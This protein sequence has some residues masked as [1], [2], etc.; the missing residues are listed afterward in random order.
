VWCVRR[1]TTVYACLFP[2]LSIYMGICKW[3]VSID[4]RWCSN[5]HSHTGM[6][7][8]EWQY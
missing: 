7:T 1:T 3:L 6:P 4:R 5:R 8:A 2:R